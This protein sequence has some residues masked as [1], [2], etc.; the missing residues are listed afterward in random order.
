MG[1]YDSK[2]CFPTFYKI[3]EKLNERFFR[4]LRK[5]V[6]KAIFGQ[7]W[8][9]FTTFAQVSGEKM[10]KN[11]DLGLLFRWIRIFREKRATSRSSPYE[12]STSCKISEKLMA[13]CLRKSV[14]DARTHARTDGRTGP[15]LYV[16]RFTTGD[17]K[18]KM[19]LCQFYSNIAKPILKK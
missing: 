16:P 8:P 10:A 12:N 15:I 4:K 13:R 18:M 1:E 14:M 5:T 2:H 19:N 7:K 3:L 11:A 9:F 17:Q 6:K